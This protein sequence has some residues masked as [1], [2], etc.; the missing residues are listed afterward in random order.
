MSLLRIFSHVTDAYAKREAK[1]DKRILMLMIGA[2]DVTPDTR[3]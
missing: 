2:K 3:S 1:E